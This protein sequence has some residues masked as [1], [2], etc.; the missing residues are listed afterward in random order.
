MPFI[1]YTLTVSVMF[2]IMYHTSSLYIHIS[3]YI[4]EI[5]YKVYIECNDFKTHTLLL[6]GGC[7]PRPL[8]LGSTTIGNPLQK[9]PCT[10]IVLGVLFNF[11]WISTTVLYNRAA[12]I[13][14]SM[15]IDAFSH[16]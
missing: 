1:L 4:I 11:G 10:E 6:A 12:H 13:I 5:K 3:S 8:H 2:C 9:F 16:R 15:F 7:A 14:D